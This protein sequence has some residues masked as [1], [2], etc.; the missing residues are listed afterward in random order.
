MGGGGGKIVLL[1]SFRSDIQHGR[2]CSHLD[3]FKRQLLNH[4]SDRIE[5]QL[6]TS[7]SSHFIIQG[8]CH[9]GKNLLLKQVGFN[10][11]LGWKH[12]WN[13]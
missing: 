2:N 12:R 5:T 10:Q 6:E 8:G 9:C 7:E 1:K 3:F 11:N 4:K 13:R